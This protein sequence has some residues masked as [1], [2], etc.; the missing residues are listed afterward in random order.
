M[1]RRHFEDIAARIKAE[2]ESYT[3][4]KVIHALLKMAESMADGFKLANPRFIRERFLA[5]CGF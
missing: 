5:A 2:K 3:N 1:T 4:A